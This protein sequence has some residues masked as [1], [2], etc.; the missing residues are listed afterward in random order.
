L[1][2]YPLYLKLEVDLIGKT[3]NEKKKEKKERFVNKKM[4]TK[5]TPKLNIDINEIEIKY[6]FK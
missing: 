6:K 4:S 1:V 3:E 5:T 2:S